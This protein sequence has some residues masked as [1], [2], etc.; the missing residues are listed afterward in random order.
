MLAATLLW[1][2]VV[3]GLSLQGL[4]GSHRIAEEALIR[5]LQTAKPDVPRVLNTF[6]RTTEQ[7]L[8]SMLAPQLVLTGAAFFF[9]AHLAAL[10]QRLN[11]AE[12]DIQV[13][14]DMVPSVNGASR[15]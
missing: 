8:F 7:I 9:V 4:R 11:A 14:R 10:K 1:L 12:R 13:M 6:D 3:Y 2:T 5:L 15:R